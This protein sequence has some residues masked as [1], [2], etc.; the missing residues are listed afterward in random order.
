MNRKSDKSVLDEM[1]GIKPDEK[2]AEL[3]KKITEQFVVDEHGRDRI[4]REVVAW[5]L[6]ALIIIVFLVVFGAVFA[7]GWHT[8]LPDKWHWL[9]SKQ[10]QDVKDFMLSGAIVSVGATYMRR[11]I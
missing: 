7:L 9:S 10:F 4:T 11:Y 6:R 5:C 8:L 3:D 2:A 1:H